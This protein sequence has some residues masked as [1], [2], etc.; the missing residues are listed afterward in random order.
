[1]SL[2][3][4]L[5]MKG[6]EDAIK[7]HP[8]KRDKELRVATKRVGSEMELEARNNHPKWTSRSGNLKNSIKYFYSV[9][10]SKAI[11][12]KLSLLSESSNKKLG[13]E[14]GKYQHDGTKSKNGK[15]KIQGD[16]WVKRAFA[17]NVKKLKSEWQSAIDKANKDF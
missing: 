12:L 2:E 9:S 10:K 5:N 14:Y 1:M 11:E 3:F 7:K 17:N 6:F 16:P 4:K 13:T 8:E 15:V